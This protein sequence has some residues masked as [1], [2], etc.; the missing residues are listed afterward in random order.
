MALVG[1]GGSTDS[2]G[3]SAKPASKPKPEG[4]KQSRCLAVPKG[5][6]SSLAAGLKRGHRLSG[7]VAVRSR[8][9][10]SGPADLTLGVY[11][12]SAD[13]KP[14][15][16]ISTWA[17][18]ERAFK[19]GGGII[20]AADPASRAVSTLGVDLSPDVLKGWG[21]SRGAEGFG[22]SQACVGK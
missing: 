4:A 3:G 19:T 16:G 2:D 15:P 13:V 17:V 10:F 7:L 21:I 5:A 1:C 22:A 12:V 8:G 18:G 11:F 6:R 20:V 14:S 9:K